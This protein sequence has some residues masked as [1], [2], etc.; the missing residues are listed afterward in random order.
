VLRHV[1]DDA[2]QPNPL[3]TIF[4]GARVQ[5]GRNAAA[6]LAPGGQFGKFNPIAVGSRAGCQRN[7]IHCGKR[8]NGLELQALVKILLKVAEGIERRPVEEGKTAGWVR[9]KNR[10]RQKVGQLPVASLAGPQGT[11][12]FVA[13]FDFLLEPAVEL[14]QIQSAFPD[15]GFE[16]FIGPREGLFRLSAAFLALRQAAGHPIEG[17]DQG[18]HFVTTTEYHRLV[19]PTLSNGPAARNQES[20]AGG[21]L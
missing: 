1:N 11:E 6:V 19:A 14:L 20:D 8:I 7:L 2:A 13:P 16:T 15:A 5:E 4:D 21:E 18:V 9:F 17:L 10:L 12:S 3:T